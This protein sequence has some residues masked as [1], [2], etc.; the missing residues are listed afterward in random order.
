PSRSSTAS[1]SPVDAPEGTAARP[2][3]S[4]SRVTSTSIVGLPRESRIWRAWTA[5]RALI[6]LSRLLSSGLCVTFGLGPQSEFRVDP[7]AP[8][9]GHRFPEQPS[10]LGFRLVAVRVG[11][12]GIGGPFFGVELPLHLV[13]V[14]QCR[15]GR[16]SPVL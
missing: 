13:G 9:L 11:G 2:V 8:G 16:F 4:F 6:W 7:Q 14:D 15:Q 3:N 12:T 1:Y 5:S 10:D